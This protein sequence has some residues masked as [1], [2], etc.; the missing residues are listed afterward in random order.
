VLE[1][2]VERAGIDRAE[3]QDVVVGCGLPEE[4]AARAYPWVSEP[5]EAEADSEGL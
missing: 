4:A 2:A 5:A 3:V 1:R